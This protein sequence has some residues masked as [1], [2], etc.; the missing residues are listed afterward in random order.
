MPTFTGFHT[1][2]TPGT[3]T[4]KSPFYLKPS[5]PATLARRNWVTVKVVTLVGP[6][7]LGGWLKQL[8]LHLSSC[9]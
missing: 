6:V 5:F 7:E 4:V 8:F 9:K 3:L 2:V 1:W